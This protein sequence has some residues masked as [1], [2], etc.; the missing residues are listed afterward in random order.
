MGINRW[1]RIVIIG[2]CLCV[3]F[4]IPMGSVLA[5]QIAPSAEDSQ[6]QPI[7][8]AGQWQ[9][10]WGQ[11]LTPADFV[12]MSDDEIAGGTTI[13]VPSSWARQVLGPDVNAGQPLPVFGVAT[14]RK[15]VEL[16]PDQVDTY[17]MVTLDS[18]GS[19]YRIWVNGTLVGGLG[20]MVAHTPTRDNDAEV[21]QIRLNLLNITPKTQQ[22]D[23]VVQ[24]SNY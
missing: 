7:S 20:T 19:A 18:V 17:L 22:L 9:F 15:Q 11:L 24:V 4:V 13:A 12:A 21:P 8:L 10:Y 1:Q 3:C 16:R 14:Y 23:I 2:F 6:T 5:A